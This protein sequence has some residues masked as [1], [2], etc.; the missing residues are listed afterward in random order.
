VT[1]RRLITLSLAGMT[2]SCT[3]IYAVVPAGGVARAK[4]AKPAMAIEAAEEVVAIVE[5]E[6]SSERVAV[7]VRA[8]HT[9]L[10]SSGARTTF[11]MLE[12]SGRDMQ[13]TQSIPSDT[14]LVIDASGSMEGARM[15]NAVAAAQGMA[16]HFST[17][18]TLS[19]TSFNERAT[20]LLNATAVDESARN[21]MY[22]ALQ[23]VRAEGNTCLS[24]GVN[25]ALTRLPNTGTRV[26]RMLLISDGEANHGSVG[27]GAFRRIAERC[28]QQD[29]SVTTIGVGVGY[30]EKVLAA[31]SFGSNGD[32]HFVAHASDLSAVFDQQRESLR[33]TSA[34]N[35]DV[36][37][38]L[39]D[40]VELVRIVDREHHREDD[41]IVVRLGMIRSD[42]AKTVLALVRVS[43]TLGE[44]PLAN[45][46]VQDND[47]IDGSKARTRSSLV[48]NVDA[49]H[50]SEL[51]PLIAMRLERNRTLVA[52]R[53][54]GDLFAGGNQQEA[55]QR[56]DAHERDLLEQAR[57]AHTEAKRR[58]DP[59]AGAIRRDFNRQL[60]QVKR[61][62]GAFKRA[63]PRSQRGRE[64]VK[65]NTVRFMPN[66]L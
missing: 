38:T 59:R 40:G 47:P 3:T 21:N 54:A 10:K 24:C 22:R 62:R 27:E 14:A 30:N 61:S 2:M 34:T 1:L 19:I 36:E 11:I 58:N 33:K 23:R 56:L 8:G 50:E 12:V 60:S 43:N 18:D 65:K 29:V 31:L 15:R 32:H 7:E 44:R 26:R 66:M 41:R 39:A 17:G 42:Q 64:A 63:A 53:D 4:L 46:L 51:D 52:M 9:A 28:R 13:H 48:I 20:V 49:T 55:L 25:T 5:Q 35:V 37:L 6:P 16:G 45:V 57:R